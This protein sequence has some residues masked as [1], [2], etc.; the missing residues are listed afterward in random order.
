MT[1]LCIKILVKSD[2]AIES[3]FPWSP[4][5]LITPPTIKPPSFQRAVSKEYR[6]KLDRNLTEDMI[7]G[8]GSDKTAVR[9][10]VP[11]VAH[12]EDRTFRHCIGA[13]HREFH[14]FIDVWFFQLLAIA[15]YMAFL[16]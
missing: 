13:V 16:K 10:V 7:H 5:L 4:S 8:Y 15:P 9:A 12:D 3:A 2:S 6:S 11:V 14:R 1:K